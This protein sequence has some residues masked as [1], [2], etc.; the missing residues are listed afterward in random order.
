MLLRNLSTSLRWAV[1]LAVMTGLALVVGVALGKLIE[2]PALAIR[3][4]LFPRTGA[5]PHIRNRTG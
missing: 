3:D 4:R 5:N 1:G 2:Y